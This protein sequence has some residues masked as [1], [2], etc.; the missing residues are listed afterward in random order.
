MLRETWLLLLDAGLNPQWH[1]TF[2]FKVNVP[3][4]AFVVFTV[5]VKNVFIAQYTIPYQCIQQGRSNVLNIHCTLIRI[6]D[7]RGPEKFRAV[8]DQV[9][10]RERRNGRSVLGRRSAGIRHRLR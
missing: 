7:S 2:F 1:E 10:A 3:E 8:P 6:N 4:L 5:L 9:V